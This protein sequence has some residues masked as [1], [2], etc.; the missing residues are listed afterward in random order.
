MRAGMRDEEKS[1]VLIRR[2][3]EAVYEKKR[4]RRI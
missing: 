1:L 4:N 3:F 2:I